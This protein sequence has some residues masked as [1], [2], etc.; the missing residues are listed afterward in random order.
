MTPDVQ[1]ARADLF[2]ALDLPAGEPATLADPVE[3]ATIPSTHPGWTRYPRRENLDTA[4]PSYTAA[5]PNAL[6]VAVRWVDREGAPWLVVF[7]HR[8]AL[9]IA[10]RPRTRGAVEVLLRTAVEVPGALDAATAALDVSGADA[11]AQVLLALTPEETHAD[12]HD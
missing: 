3:V 2:A 9:A 10:K 1:A 12:V 11:A 7:V 5:V 4:L 8:L 6:R